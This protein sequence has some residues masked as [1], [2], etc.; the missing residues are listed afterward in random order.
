M[1]E[2][3]RLTC[4]PYACKRTSIKKKM[5]V[6]KQQHFRPQLPLRGQSLTSDGRKLR[7]CLLSSI[8]QISVALSLHGDG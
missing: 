7:L 8:A 3:T 5:S 6:N 2:T 4:A 1:L